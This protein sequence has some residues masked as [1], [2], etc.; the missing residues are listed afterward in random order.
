MKDLKEQQKL[1]K[2]YSIKQNEYHE[3]Q[4][5][6]NVFLHVFSHDI[7]APIRIID[8]FTDLLIEDCKSMLDDIGIRYTQVIKE[9]A[10]QSQKIINA[11]LV[12]NETTKKE[13]EIEEINSKELIN[14]IL[15]SLLKE[16]AYLYDK[17][18]IEVDAGLHS[19]HGDYALM[20]TLFY[21]IIENATKFTAPNSK[22]KIAITSLKTEDSTRFCFKDNGL[23]FDMKYQEKI[24]SPFQKAHFGDTFT[25]LGM[26]LSVVKYIV[27]KHG[28]NVWAESSLNKGASFF[29]EIPD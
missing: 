22:S 13:I 25:G 21:H 14:C 16:N 5:M 8:G 26:G 10:V 17:N 24:F 18:N 28:G 29:V 3:L 7:A 20:R 11:L 2:A 9:N 19:F 12:Y 15:N 6:F 23:G 27:M 1:A 4:N